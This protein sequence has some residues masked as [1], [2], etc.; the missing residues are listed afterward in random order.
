[1]EKLKEVCI[2]E[3]VD[4]PEGKLSASAHIFCLAVWASISL[5]K[6]RVGRNFYRDVRSNLRI[7]RDLGSHFQDGLILL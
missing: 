7:L 1:M 4:L 6:L 3:G 2:C 5:T